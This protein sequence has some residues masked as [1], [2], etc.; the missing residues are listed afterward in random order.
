MYQGFYCTSYNAWVG[1]CVGVSGGRR[2]EGNEGE[3]QVQETVLY[4]LS[5]SHL[6]RIH[7]IPS[8]PVVDLFQKIRQQVK[9]YLMTASNM[10]T[11]ELQEVHT[12]I[13]THTQYYQQHTHT[14]Y[15]QQHTHTHTHTV[16]LVAHTH[17]V[18]SVAHVQSHRLVVADH[19]G[20]YMVATI[21]HVVIGSC[22]LVH[23]YC[24]HQHLLLFPLLK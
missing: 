10:E 19:R 12:H 9:C 21:I 15:C 18:L 13:H 8:V 3:W 16:L 2:Q 4:C 6:Y 22:I 11:N 20:S 17:T 24:T 14:Q 1:V 7:S 23:T 5:L